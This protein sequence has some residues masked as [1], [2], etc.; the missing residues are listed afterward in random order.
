L[1]VTIGSL[2]PILGTGAEEKGITEA[3][4]LKVVE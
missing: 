1:L 3:L 4:G 2:C